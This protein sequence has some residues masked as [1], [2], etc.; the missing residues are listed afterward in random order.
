MRAV[1]LADAGVQDLI[2]QHFIPLKIAIQPGTPRL[3]L[4]WPALR[5]WQL[6]YRLMGGEECDGFTACMV[7]S[8]DLET[9][10]GNTGSAFVWEM[11]DSI[12]YD[13]GRFGAMLERAAGYAAAERELLAQT[14]LTDRQRE[15]Q[16]NVMRR[17]HGREIGRHGRFRLPPPGFN[18]DGAIKL[19]ELTGDIP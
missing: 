11:F 13:A 1:A 6:S 14:D 7:V 8:H 17:Q 4:D 9:E 2:A 18:I 15:R 16:L 10:H 12:A 19:F 5:S 3:P